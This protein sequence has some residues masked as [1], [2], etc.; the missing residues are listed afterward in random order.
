SDIVDAIGS[1]EGYAVILRSELVLSAKKELDLT[2]AV[3]KRLNESKG[4]PTKEEPE[5]KPGVKPKE[6]PKGKK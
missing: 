5:V 1:E 6:K 3:I 4:K 2:S